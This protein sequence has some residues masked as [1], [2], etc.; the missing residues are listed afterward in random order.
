MLYTQHAH[1]RTLPSTLITSGSKD[2]IPLITWI[3]LTCSFLPY[4]TK[5][6]FYIK[7][8]SIFLYYFDH[9]GWKRAKGSFYGRHIFKLLSKHCQISE[10]KIP[11]HV[12]LYRMF[13]N[14][15]PHAF[16]GLFLIGRAILV[17]GGASRNC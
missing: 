13:T 7:S 1:A 3:P 15:V 14:I 8:Q 12:F 17:R 9:H 10:P 16:C 6:Y 5:L 4:L 2:P 11:V